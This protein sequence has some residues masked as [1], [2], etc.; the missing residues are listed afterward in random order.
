MTEQLQQA[1]NTC[2]D[3]IA[4]GEPLEACLQDYPEL[5]DQLRVLLSLG[6]MS[7]RARATQ[8]E[9]HPAR[10]RLDAQF[11]ER[12]AEFE[13]SGSNWR[14]PEGASVLLVASLIAVLFGFLALF[15]SDSQLDVGG[16]A[17]ETA[18]P[19]TIQDTA[20]PTLTL[21]DT[22][23]PTNTLTDT[24]IPT[25][26]LT[27][28]PIPTNTLTP[29]DAVCVPQQPA[30]WVSYR[31]QL[32]DSVSLIVVNSGADREEFLTANCIEDGRS[33]LVGQ[34]IYV[35]RLW[36]TSTPDIAPTIT[37]TAQSSGSVPNIQITR[38]ASNEIESNDSEDDYEEDEHEE[39]DY[40]ED[41]H[42]EDSSESD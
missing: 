8:A 5:A 32:N 23:I 39:D 16:E 36:A 18:T 31:V 3:R 33:I 29:T 6:Q 25:N 34:T 15:Q 19:T 11:E 20:E 14:L 2:I 38:K 4:K 37:A 40:E 13:V 1:L 21:T 42:E 12:L 7:S 26:T 17:T 35:P 22:P 24:P 30:G 10:M 41:E 9:L 28:T 27:N